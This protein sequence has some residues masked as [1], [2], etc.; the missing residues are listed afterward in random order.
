MKPSN[1]I[2]SSYSGDYYEYG[3]LR[4]D[5]PYFAYTMSHPDR[6]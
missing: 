3:L 4:C 5:L 1:W 6:L 2:L